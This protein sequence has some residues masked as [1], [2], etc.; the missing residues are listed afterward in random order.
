MCGKISTSHKVSWTF[1]PI[2]HIAIY[3]PVIFAE[4][5]YKNLF[6]PGFKFPCNLEQIVKFKVSNCCGEKY[7]AN[8]IV[9]LTIIAS[10]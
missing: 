9:K 10:V 6:S 3:L 4:L 5:Q 2:D 7:F 1:S 8:P